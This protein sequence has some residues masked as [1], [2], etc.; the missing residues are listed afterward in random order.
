MGK[1]VQKKIIKGVLKTMENSQ[2]SRTEIVKKPF[3]VFLSQPM[4]GFTDE[5]IQ[6]RRKNDFEQLKKYFGDQ[7]FEI[8]DTI[9]EQN[10]KAK[11][12]PVEYLA[13][14]I[15]ELA[16]ADFIAMSYNFEQ[17]RGCLIEHKIAEEYGI[18]IIYLN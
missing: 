1:I 6:T 9:F 13:R 5:E 4:R 2:E 11:H 3:K 15:A 10:A 7:P 12:I 16:N 18:G 8:I 17:A 14:S